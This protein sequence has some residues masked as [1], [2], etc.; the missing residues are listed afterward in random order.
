MEQELF[1]KIA[2]EIF[3]GEFRNNLGY[4]EKKVFDSGKRQNVE[5]LSEKLDDLLSA[6]TLNECILVLSNAMV[7]CWSQISERC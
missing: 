7:V 2:G 4:I 3:D 1:E 5:K 6:Y